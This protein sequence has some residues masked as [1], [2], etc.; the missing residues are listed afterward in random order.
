V[1]DLVGSNLTPTADLQEPGGRRYRQWY[2]RP[3]RDQNGTARSCPGL[4]LALRQQRQ[5]ALLGARLHLDG[6]LL[7]EIFGDPR[8]AVAERLAD[9]LGP[10]V[11]C[12][13]ERGRRVPRRVE[14]DD[15]QS[16]LCR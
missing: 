9:D 13:R 4:P 5:K 1:T 3:E 2:R 11:R 15:G 6:H 10:D 7:V 12:K 8:R 16:G 14:L